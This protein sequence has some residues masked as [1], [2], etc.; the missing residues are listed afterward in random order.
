MRLGWRIRVL[1]QPR[2]RLVA[3]VPIAPSCSKQRM[4]AMGT[5]HAARTRGHETL[6]EATR[7]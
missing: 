6:G 7:I 2:A 4:G 1:R 3:L 5:T